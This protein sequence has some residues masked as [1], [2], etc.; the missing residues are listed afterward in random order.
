MNYAVKAKVKKFYKR[1]PIKVVFYICALAFISASAISIA[2]GYLL[3]PKMSEKDN[4]L[5]KSTYP[6]QG[7]VD[8]NYKRLFV[9][10][11]N[12]INSRLIFNSSGEVPVEDRIEEKKERTDQRE[13]T[14]LDIKLRGIIFGGASENGVALIEN[15]SGGRVQVNYFV[16]GDRITGPS[17]IL[18]GIFADRIY[19]D[20]DGAKEYLIL[21]QKELVK[22]KRRKRKSIAKATETNIPKGSVFETK[23]QEAGFEKDGLDVE[24]SSAFKS[25]LI[26][27][28]EN[29]K[30]VLQDA[31]AIPAKDPNTGKVIGFKLINIK[32]DSIYKKFG[33]VDGDVITEIN[34]QP[35]TNPV[36]AVSILKNA[37]K[38]KQ[39]QINILSKGKQREFSV[40]QSD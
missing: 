10:E 24:F 18:S 38:A 30:K 9:A 14:E 40:N 8:T 25:N 6:E 29:F 28:K 36:A 4:I 2:I 37:K 35:L 19:I 5:A 34:G 20:N 17:V 33:L 11:R 21:D 3:V 1:I 31:K 26:D 27:N 15:K 16:V 13:L 22:N 39:Y 32:Q 23:Y 12:L 7:S